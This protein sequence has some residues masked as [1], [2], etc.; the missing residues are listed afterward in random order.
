MAMTCFHLH[1]FKPNIFPIITEATCCNS[2][3]KRLLHIFE[4]FHSWFTRKTIVL[5]NYTKLKRGLVFKY[6][7][8]IPSLVFKYNNNIS[9]LVF[10]YNNNMPSIL[11]SRISP[12]APIERSISIIDSNSYMKTNSKNLICCIENIIQFKMLYW[13]HNWAWTCSRNNYLKL[14]L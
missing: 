8:N 7:N 4:I 12:E 2:N 3:H 13:W 14:Y 6:N 5:Q 9:C 11:V 10:K 1:R